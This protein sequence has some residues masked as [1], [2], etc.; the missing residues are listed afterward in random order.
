M[1]ERRAR[2]GYGYQDK[3]ATERILDSLRKDLRAG[4]AD[5]E[6]VRL[7]DLEAGRVDD[8]VLVWKASVEGNS[9]KWSGGAKPFLWSDL[10][11][12]SGMLGELADGWKVLRDH[13][14]PRPITVRLH[15]NRPAS[16]ARHHAQLIPSFSVADFV[17][18][19]WPSGPDAADSDEA[20]EA[21]GRIAEEVDLPRSQLSEFVEN[22]VLVFG[23]PQPPG[24]GPGNLDWQHY[25]RQ[26]DHLHKAIATWLTN[27]PNEEF[28]ERDYLLAAIGLHSSRSGLI[29]R[30][31]KPSIPYQE[32]QP[33]AAKL[34]AL[35]DA[36]PGGYIALTGVAGTGK[37]TLVQKVLTDS[38]HPYFVPY[39]AFL[40]STPGNR[41]RSEALTFFQDVIA[42]L[43][44]FDST[45]RSLGVADLAQGRSAL[46]RHMSSANQRFVQDGRKTILLIDGLDHVM[47]E[48]N[49]QMPV[50]NELPPPSEIPDGFLIILSSQPQALLASV[51]PAMVAATVA[52]P[53]RRLAVGGL[54]RAEVHTLVSNLSKPTT[55][56]ERDLLHRASL[57]NP[58]VLTYLLLLLERSDDISVV[59]ALGQ[60]GDYV[61]DMDQYYRERLSISL[62]DGAT[63][64]LL[65]LL[66]RAV[67][68][69]PVRWL[70][71]WPE[72]EAIEDICQTALAPFVRV[73][74][75]MVTFLHDSLVAFLRVETRSRLT[76][77]DTEEDERRFYSSLAD[78]S[79]GRSCLDVIGR[80][81][82]VFLM[83][84]R[85]YA[86]VLDQLSSDWLRAGMHGFLPYA[87]LRP[88]LLAGYAAASALGRWGDILRLLLLNHELD[89][90]TSRVEAAS[91][92]KTL[93]TLDEPDL[94]LSQVI[95]D[96]QLLVEE[97]AALRFAGTMQRYARQRNRSELMRRAHS[98][99]HQAKP[100][101]II[102]TDKS[103]RVGYHD[104][105]FDTVRAWSDVAPL[106]EPADLVI[107]EI[108]RLTLVLREGSY[109]VDP[110][111]IRAQ[112]L[113]RG[114]STALH[115]DCA[116]AE[117]N[118]FVAAIRLLGSD[119]WK[120]VALLR[121]AESMPSEVDSEALRALYE[122]SETDR[123]IDIAYARFLLR[124]GD[125]KAATEIV[126]RLSHIRFRLHRDRHSWGFSDVTFTIQL[127]WLQ[128]ILGIPEGKVR[129]ARNEREE[130]HVRVE[131]V[132][133]QL[134]VLMALAEADEIPDDYSDLFRSL[135]LF[136][137]RSIHFS[138][139]GPH[140]D[141]IALLSRTSVYE[142][143]GRLAGV[144]GQ[145][146]L[147]A[148]RD[149]VLELTSR[150]SVG[151]QFI[152]PH[153]RQFAQLFYEEGIMSRQEAVTLGLST[154]RDAS[155]EDPAQRQEACLEIATFLHRVGDEAGSENWR[156][157]A[158]EVSAGAGSYKDYHM[159]HVADWLVRSVEDLPSGRWAILHRFARAVEVAGG[160]GE[161]HGAAELLRLVGR[162]SPD[163]AWRLAMEFIDR[164]V[165][166][167]SAALE[168]LL[169]GSADRGA[170]PELLSAVYGEV[171]AL[172]ASGD[173]SEIAGN[174]LTTF[175]RD[176]MRQAA[177]RLMADV[178]TNALPSSRAR[179]ARVLQD[180]VRSKELEPVTL[181]VG[182]M[183]E[184]DYPAPQG[185]LY[186]LVTGEVQT[187]DQVVERLGDP[188]R[189]DTWDPNPEG[190]PDFD[191]WTAIG[192]TNVRD[193]DHLANLI[194]RFP[195]PDYR[196]AELLVREADILLRAGDRHSAQ[197]VIERAIGRATDGSWHRMVDGGQKVLVFAMLKKIDHD[198]GRDR[199]RDEFLR[200]L[201]AGKPWSLY[202]LADI[203]EILDFLEVNW[204]G[205]AVLD[206]VD[207]YLEQVL[208]ANPEVRPYESLTGSALSWSADRALC[209]F[210]VELLVCP[211]IDVGVAARRVLAKYLS[212]DER[213][214]SALLTDAPP[215][216]PLQLEHLLAAV[217]L[218]MS[219]GSVRIEGLRDFTEDLKHSESLSV[220]S[221]AK[222]ICDGQGWSW[223]DVTTASARPVILMPNYSSRSEEAEMMI[224]GETAI[225]WDSHEALIRPLL[226][227]GLD[228]EELRSE[229]EGIYWKLK[230][231]YPWTDDGRLQHWAKQFGTNFYLIPTEVIGREA[232]MRVFGRRSLSGQVAAGAEVA[233]DKFYPIYDPIVEVQQ[234]APRPV[235]LEGMARH[236]MDGGEKAW[237]QGAGASK[238]DHYPSAIRERS[239][240]GE[241]TFLVRPDWE[242]PREERCR[243]LVADVA[244]ESDEGVLKSVRELT[245]KTYLDGWGQ[246]GDALI[247]MNRRI[248]LV[249]RRYRWAAINANVAR[250]LGWHPSPNVPFQWL[251]TTG[252]VMVESTFWRDGWIRISPPRNECFG[253]GWVVSASDAAVEAIRRFAPEAKIHLW[254]E[255]HC[256]TQ[257]E[258]KWH[259]SRPL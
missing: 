113:F 211:V 217:H 201:S 120:F 69:L 161:T 66:C 174:V 23:Q 163:R 43:D 244:E 41:D 221:V 71:E 133:R 78:R 226:A 13:W 96:S 243:G 227:Y 32:N 176:Q 248:Q 164:G 231:E 33:A 72:W 249:G 92:A 234:P 49:L 220:R 177:E 153:R 198:D 144:M 53:E 112:L 255:R 76:D 170:H 102:H 54:S 111:T 91:L 210:V 162:L 218:G 240:I 232:A 178:S 28:I 5:F 158:T 185:S 134:G 181:T 195:P 140:H 121:L 188:S 197:D 18:N 65:G 257:L 251:D 30:F 237:R 159:E 259:L 149:V 130:E 209:R 67:P 160:M 236:L 252:A 84:A 151:E 143:I 22:C 46:R 169:R 142:Q 135:L 47:R 141:P 246:E 225:A 229:F 114:L 68:T 254:V 191:W 258:G 184:G 109:D 10:I 93:L 203:G 104:E 204:P 233:Y 235:E 165:L 222:R 3:V 205:E 34:N 168:A 223:E 17:D 6:G 250:A 215:W 200:D 155:D 118:A 216:S 187:L 230:N 122:V 179:V 59:E 247:I 86:D 70:S 87:H 212:M 108:Q 62:E 52:K 38:T 12:A 166:N 128:E 63:R 2:W 82:V 126:S 90:R 256:Q 207:D 147:E 152:A 64:R 171:H 48:R 77:D 132:A 35:V 15:T 7:A 190:N 193:T 9:I 26:F 8:F 180:I 127:R 129:Q 238:W 81:Q 44:R 105:E 60:A 4:N 124:E 45:R 245:Y 36:T 98:L 20:R 56:E 58:L 199:A 167:V 196:Q 117:C 194:S 83:R 139:G 99:Y 125:R 21:W 24:P 89:A 106:F 242:W 131:H 103:I 228:V 107:D 101:A 182:V 16:D 206:A 79:E 100:I 189:P 85:R 61:G 154:T 50:L 110:V 1:G 173:T 88:V 137:N 175:P 213:G 148:L 116:P 55:D 39:Y 157:R 11:G 19:H 253:E 224:G 145:R 40:P 241:R 239:I 119:M 156:R 123:G 29:Q 57:G 51:I 186:R 14:D 138:T 75:G 31:P 42:R 219:F 146:G 115:A 172:I 202:L 192:K 37:S 74:E 208:A 136:H 214:L 73:E 183:P 27:N 95:S 80:A 94:A 150:G 25:L 97:G